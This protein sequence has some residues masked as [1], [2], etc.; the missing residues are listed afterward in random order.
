MYTC[1]VLRLYTP[2]QNLRAGLSGRLCA[3]R[4]VGAPSPVSLPNSPPLGFASLPKLAENNVNGTLHPNKSTEH[5]LESVKLPARPEDMTEDA[6]LEAL[7]REFQH[8]NE[9]A[10]DLEPPRTPTTPR[11]PSTRSSSPERYSYTPRPSSPELFEDDSVLR[12]LHDNLESRL[13][14]FWSSVL[15][16]RPVRIRLYA[17]PEGQ[18]TENAIHSPHGPIAAA[19]VTTSPDGSFEALFRVPWEH[20]CQH[21]E[22]LHIAFGEARQ[23]HEFA[24]VVD[25]LPPRPTPQQLQ[26][27]Q[28]TYHRTLHIM[29]VMMLS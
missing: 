11:S 15:P 28:Q 19:N 16:S 26:Q 14:P 3:L 20:L 29:P 25:L 9:E 8:A 17:A 7:D 23:E 10:A 13:R 2:R 6:E 18:P 4:K 5:I 22:A 27:Q 1:L 12:K 24:V 21:P